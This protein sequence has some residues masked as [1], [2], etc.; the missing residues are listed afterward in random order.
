MLRISCENPGKDP[1]F[2]FFRMHTTASTARLQTTKRRV[3]CAAIP[4][5]MLDLLDVT[6]RTDSNIDDEAAG[7]AR[8]ELAAASKTRRAEESRAQAA[9]NAA[10]Q[11]KNKAAG[12]RTDDN[13]EDEEAGRMRLELAA[14]SK[15]RK[16]DEA[17][18]LAAKNAAQRQRLQKIKAAGART[19]DNLDDVIARTRPLAP[20]V[21]ALCHAPPGTR[22]H[23]PML[24]PAHRRK[25]AG[26]AWSSRQPRRHA[27]R[28]NS[29]S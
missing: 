9:R 20:L 1:R 18:A 22:A 4:K 15:T 2:V 27:V 23:G 3:P 28:T 8:H 12:P 13:I 5:P 19:D 16:T 17:R 29:A 25:P 11:Q 6:G 26:C 14:A 21:H 24:S 7:R 10:Q